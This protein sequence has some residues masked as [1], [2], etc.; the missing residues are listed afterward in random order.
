MQA[1]GKP[2]RA[3]RPEAMRLA[4]GAVIVTLASLAGP[5]AAAVGDTARVYLTA[6]RFLGILRREL[7]LEPRTLLK[8]IAVPLACALGMCCLLVVLQATAL[9]DWSPHRRLIACV[10]IGAASYGL[11]LVVFGRTFVG[12]VLGSA[13]AGLPTPLRRVADL[14]LSINR[15]APLSRAGTF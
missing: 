6:P 13:K 3:I 7:G 8:G 10:A 9:A 12:D 2:D 11:L 4:S 1:I 15:I 5:L 14:W